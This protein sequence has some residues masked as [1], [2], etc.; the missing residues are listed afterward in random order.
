MKK[1]LALCLF[2]TLSCANKSPLVIAHRQAPAYL[3]EHT[4]ESATLAHG[5]NP[6]YLEIDVVMTRD[7]HLV[8][9]HDIHLDTVTN[10][11]KKYSTR[12][13][14]DGR[15]YAIDFTLKEIK[16][17]RVHERSSLKTGKQRY[18]KRFPKGNSHFQVPSLEEFIELLQG[19]NT[20][21]KKDI[22][23][24]IEYKSPAFHRRN[25]KDIEKLV[26][27]KLKSYGYNDQNDKV[28]LQC[29][30]DKSLKRV[31]YQ[32]KSKL[33]LVQLIGENSWGESK[34]DYDKLKTA[35]GLKEISKYAVGIGP[36]I[37]HVLDHKSGGDTGFIKLAHQN[38]LVVH[39]YTARAD[40]LPKWASN[41]DHLLS[42]LEKVG[43]DGVFTDFPDL[44]RKKY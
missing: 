29:F 21:R 28:F 31:K 39:P 6:D 41:F 35:E 23:L 24:Y 36:W 5:M 40:D 10:V 14:S 11:A 42:A 20:V 43:I 18:A 37:H 25:K 34:T 27:N 7:N 8:I 19:L 33:K 4:L 17:L 3:P 12:K 32:L 44:A 22:G 1:I 16:K 30:D 38:N 26:L 13:R 15:Y 2:L 9:L